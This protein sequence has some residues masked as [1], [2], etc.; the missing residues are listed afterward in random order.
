MSSSG[1]FRILIP[2]V[3]VGRSSG[4]L[5]ESSYTYKNRSL[6]IITNDDADLSYLLI[7]FICVISVCFIVAI[8][9]FVSVLFFF[10]FFFF[11]FY[12]I[13]KRLLNLLYIFINYAKIVFQ[14]QLLKKY[15]LKSIKKQINT[16]HV[17]YV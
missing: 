15:Q 16:I 8:S 11:N 5:I 14:N 13:F 17:L 3:F 9:I 6:I 4:Y 10:F 2:S 1:A 7:P 12:S